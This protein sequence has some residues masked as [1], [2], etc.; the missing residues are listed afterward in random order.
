MS[1][2][3]SITHTLTS[4]HCRL[5]AEEQVGQSGLSSSGHVGVQVTAVFAE[6]SLTRF[7]QRVTDLIVLSDQLLPG[8]QGVSA[9]WA[10]V[11][12]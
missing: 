5:Q 6:V 9:L 3:L 11:L 10:D 2:T 12:I 7:S 4:V 8:G 1:C